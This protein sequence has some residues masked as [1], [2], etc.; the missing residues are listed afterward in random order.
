MEFSVRKNVS[1][2]KCDKSRI[3]CDEEKESKRTSEMRQNQ[4]GF[5]PTRE[6]QARSSTKRWKEAA[7][8]SIHS[9]IHPFIHPHQSVC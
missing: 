1:W 6:K 5:F 7:N 4:D 2:L 8:P 3:V 9:S